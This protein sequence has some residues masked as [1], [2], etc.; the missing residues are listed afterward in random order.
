MA[1]RVASAS[2]RAMVL[3]LMVLFSAI[4]QTSEARILKVGQAMQGNANNSHHI[5]LELG[6]DLSK[7]GHFRRLST[8]DVASDRLSPGGPDPHHHY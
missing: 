4:C 5:L 3:L 7:L 6:F 8:L 2:S 1:S